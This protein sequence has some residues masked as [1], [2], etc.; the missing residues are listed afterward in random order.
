M[1]R[2]SLFQSIIAKKSFLCVGLDTDINRIPAHLK[3]ADDPIFE[4]NKEII[5][6]T[7][8]LVI[9]YKP[10]LAF[11]EALGPKGME[12]F[13]KT[14]NY[15]PD[16][17]L[18]IADAKRGDIGNTSDLY[19]RSFFEYY[20]VDALTV[21]PYMGDDS[22]TPFS[23][24]NDRWVIILGLTSNSGSQDFQQLQFPDKEHLYEKV[25][26]TCSNYGTADNLMFVIGA[27]KAESFSHIRTIIPDHFCLVPG[28]GAQGG[29]LNAVMEHGLNDMV[30]LIVN[31]SRSIIYA[32]SEK[33]FGQAART[34]ALDLQ[35]QMEKGLESRGFFN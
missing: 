14:V 35:Q 31:S 17:I 34:K 30:G 2:E 6:N 29:D 21:A 25:L 22:I 24:F 23:K 28:I 20:D 18:T 11:Y 15:I 8:D 26:K 27:T 1:S 33:D 32:S 16:N 13:H 5:D 10:N 19:A 4:F 3:D 7:H 12:S 9:A